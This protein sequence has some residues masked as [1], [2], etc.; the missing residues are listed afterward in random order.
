MSRHP[1]RGGGCHTTCFRW[2]GLGVALTCRQCSWSSCPSTC[3][4]AA[5]G[6][7]TWA[8][9]ARGRP[10]SRAH[11]QG[12][13][14]C[15]KVSNAHSAVVLRSGS[16]PVPGGQLQVAGCREPAGDW[17]RLLPAQGARRGQHGGPAPLLSRR[18][19][20]EPTHGE[21]GRAAK[22]A[23]V[24]AHTHVLGLPARHGPFSKPC[25]LSAAKD[26]GAGEGTWVAHSPRGNP[27]GLT[28][29]RAHRG[30]TG[31]GTS[32]PG[33]SARCRRPRSRRT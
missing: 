7:D 31:S 22:L 28:R 26:A 15:A 8:C 16:V 1:N 4:V 32:S 3:A 25:A 11:T 20:W 17:C 12:V 19:A 14:P 6:W 10:Q 9:R 29:P 23:A 21:Q 24:H 2:S 27:L 18:L 13:V 30:L 33:G 5:T